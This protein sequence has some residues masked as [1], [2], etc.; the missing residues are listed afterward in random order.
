MGDLSSIPG[1][2]RSPGEGNGYPL[3]YSGLEN[4]MDCIE[5]DTT[6]RL[7]LSLS[8]QWGKFYNDT[9]WTDGKIEDQRVWVN[10]LSGKGPIQVLPRVM[11]LVS[12]ILGLESG[13]W[14]SAVRREHTVVVARYRAT[15]G[16]GLDKEM[17]RT[18]DGS[19]YWPP[20]TSLPV[21]YFLLSISSAFPSVLS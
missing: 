16:L 10:Y 3:Q 21:S 13:T 12:G 15:N 6:E 14:I 4:S 8:R 2:E 20:S 9:N 19:G 7:L 1:L 18:L 17:I 5:L 11:G